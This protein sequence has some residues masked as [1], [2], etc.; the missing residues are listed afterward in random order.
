[1]AED[2]QTSEVQQ[3]SYEDQ[4]AITKLITEA[5]GNHGERRYLF[6]R[7]WYRN[8]LFLT[9]NQWI[10][11]NKT[12][13]QWKEKKLPDWVPT[14]VT[15]RFASTGERL[16]SVLSRIEPNWIFVP[17]SDAE[18]D[19]RAAE[20]ADKVEEIVA[21]E[22]DVNTLREKVAK[23]LTYT[24]NCVAIPGVEPVFDYPYGEPFSGDDVA[25]EGTDAQGVPI[26]A[27]QEPQEYK[28]YTDIKA[29]FEVFM[30]HSIEDIKDQPE[31]LIEEYRDP[32]YIK[33]IYKVD[34]Q[35]DSSEDS[36]DYMR[37]IGNLATD[38]GSADVGTSKN[39]RLEKV[40]VHRYYKQ[41]CREWPEGLYAVKVNDMILEAMPLPKLND[42]KP[43]WN[44][45]QYK[46]DAVPGASWGRTPMSDLV[47]K[48]SQLNRL[49]SLI[50]LITIRM[51]SPVWL[52][53]EGTVVK[54]FSGEPGAKIKYSQIGDKSARPDRI[55]G[56][57]IPASLLQWREA[58]IKDF[59]ELASTFE[60]LKGEAPYSGAPG[61]VIEQLIEQGMTRFGPVLRGIAEG[62]RKWMKIEL[63]FFR[64]YGIHE[65]TLAK[66]G[67]SSRWSI[68]KFSAADFE[69]AVNVRIES[70]STVP[71]SA[72]V[73]AAKTMA[74]VNADLIDVNDTLTRHK[75][76]KELSLGHLMEA[77]SE[78]VLDAVKENELLM[79]IPPEEIP[80]IFE[81]AQQASAITGG[82]IPPQLPIKVT[83]FLDNHDIHIAKHRSFVH[84][85]KGEPYKDL[86]MIHVTE[87]FM[88]Q[89]AE[90]TPAQPVQG[91]AGGGE[92]D[93]EALAPQ[94]EG[95]PMPG[96]V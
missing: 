4:A 75:V 49:D 24:G 13:Q 15:N 37:L 40:I 86:M 7:E 18:E 14:P 73:T 20:Q 44:L 34:V 67:D 88:I 87:H 26:P 81:Q 64:T 46:F 61:V 32:K 89:M 43:L 66:L 63:E 41:P 58:L 47:S 36:L 22:N 54:N 55:P 8:L 31:V 90:M 19:I 12:D 35:P 68:D 72:Q 25:L 60:A 16:A 38:I 45:I 56:E 69:G 27:A 84:S 94:P 77:T 48:Q 9:G 80:L 78:D 51:S 79:Q 71:R 85:N 59:E 93:T 82:N 95:A 96:V 74:A 6:T 83:Q 3:A 11:W 33:D 50:E 70:D 57:Q 28:F 76:L 30:D 42:G 39:S 21:E 65:R 5:R 62:W 10:R 92:K 17:G 1:M 23:W 53:P 52:I 29:P 2:Q 91:G